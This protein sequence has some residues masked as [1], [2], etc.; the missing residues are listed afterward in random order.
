M[1][2]LNRAAELQS[3]VTEWRRHL[4]TKPELLF[5]VENTAAFVENKL[6]EFGVDEI[7][8]GLG[9]TGVVGLIKGNLGE[10]R[11]IGLRADMDALPMTETSGKPWASTTAGKMHACGHDGHTAMLLGAAK[12]LAETR[13]FKG[14]V[15][16][17]FQPAEEGGG[18]GNEM[19]KDGMMERFAIEEVYGMHNMPG[20]PVGQF[21]SRIGPIMASTDEF[22]I[23]IDGRGG[24][25]AQPHK[26][27]DPI[28]IGSQIVNAL[29]TIAS[30]TVDPLASVVVSVTKFNAG[31]AHNIIPEQ[32]VLA[33]TV[34]TL[35]PEVRDLA[36]GRIKQI[37]ESLGSAYGAKI[38]VSYGRNYPVTVNHRQETGHA[39]SAAANIAGEN[40]VS[41]DLDPMMGGEDFSYM[42]LARPGAF[43]FIGNGDTAGLHNPAYDFN[44]EAI[45]HGISYWV[46]LAEM[47][48]AA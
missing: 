43:I 3:E 21:G 46:K 36:E 20:M 17:I 40:Q 25:A 13:N 35:M 33:G 22:T 6:K 31:F 19:V 42:L 37:S 1:P 27:I 11:T 34:R 24:H 29:Q 30:R 12:Y 15:A 16:V 5:A 4:H 44:D 32:A 41:D 2:I 9:R 18:G 48:L 47:R 28:V 38:K 8:T 14:A 10:G 39:L 26:T 45:P 23:T 7:V